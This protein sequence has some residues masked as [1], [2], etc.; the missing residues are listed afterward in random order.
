MFSFERL[1]GFCLSVCRSHA[2]KKMTT[3]KGCEYRTRAIIS[4][5]L[6]ISMSRNFWK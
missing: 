3:E 4:T 5:F 2:K 6:K 1:S